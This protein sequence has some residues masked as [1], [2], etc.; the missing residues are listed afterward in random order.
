MELGGV[1]RSLLGLLNAIDYGRYDVD[2]F[3]MRRWPCPWRRSSR[4][5][6]WACCAGG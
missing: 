4:A 3:L 1:E 2:L 6:N 5:D